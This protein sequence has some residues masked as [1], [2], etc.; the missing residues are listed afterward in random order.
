MCV[1]VCACGKGGGIFGEGVC[2][3]VCTYT[4]FLQADSYPFHALQ[5]LAVCCLDALFCLPPVPESVQ[6]FMSVG[7]RGWMCST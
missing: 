7:I 3:H 5:F 2:M 1:C 4:E 6:S